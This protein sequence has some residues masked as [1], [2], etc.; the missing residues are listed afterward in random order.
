LTPR[1]TILAALATALALAGA[2]RA[3][4]AGPVATLVTPVRGD[5][6]KLDAWL[7]E[8]GRGRAALAESTR[9]I[10]LRLLGKVGKDAAGRG[11]D[12]VAARLILLRAAGWQLTGMDASEV[13]RWIRERAQEELSDRLAP[14]R[15]K[16]ILDWVLYELLAFPDRHTPLLRAVALRA[17][18]GRL[19]AREVE[20]HLLVAIMSAGRDRD[21]FVR[22]TV[23]D[24]LRGRPEPFVTD[25]FL[26][27]L[28]RREVSPEAFGAHLDALPDKDREAWLSTKGARVHDYVRLRLESKDWREASRA[29][30][31]APR[32]EPVRIVPQLITGLGVW[33]LRDTGGSR[34]IRSEYRRTLKKVTGRDYGEDPA[35]WARW[36]QSAVEGGSIPEPEVAAGGERTMATF[37]GLRPQSD[38]VLFLID[39]SGSMRERLE[40]QSTRFQ[41][42]IERLLYTLK[43]LGPETRFGVVLF[44]AKGHP[45]Q[46]GLTVADEDGLARLERWAER[47]RP[48]GGTSL[49]AGL[50]AGLPGLDDGTLIPEKIAYDTVVVLCDGE[51]ESSAWVAPWLAQYNLDARLV[52][53]CVNIGGKPGG[54]LEA[55]AA[56]SGGSFVAVETD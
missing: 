14:G 37:Y 49:Y 12:C 29:L 1:T 55:L 30:A 17:L 39:R 26:G 43:D 47:I 25:Y 10:Y 32:F 19:E 41:D 5:V 35:S 40:G 48:D 38:R 33:S 6:E 23:S 21:G 7:E 56:G 20:P 34:R 27:A 36:W 3:D 51:T 31:L 42:A 15:G 52:F 13:T 11:K 22:L 44:N 18:Q 8:Y 46:S 2:P 53:H 50:D 24:I 45:F 4:P 9:E 54:V 28:E 16:A